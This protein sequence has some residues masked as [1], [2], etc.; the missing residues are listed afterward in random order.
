VDH[1]LP[2]RPQVETA[3]LH[4]RHELDDDAR[5][6]AGEQRS[7]VADSTS[8][9]KRAFAYFYC[10]RTEAERR[11]PENILR[12]FL[13]QLALSNGK[14]LATLH[15]KYMEKKRQGFLSNSLSLTECQELLIKMISQYS[16]TILILDALDECE[17]DSR[18]NFMAVFSRLVEQNLPVRIIISSRPD[19]DISAEFGDGTNF[20]LSATDNS[21][22]IMTFVHGKIEDYRNSKKSK[23]RINSVISDELEQQ[24]IDVFQEKSDGMSV[25]LSTSAARQLTTSRFQWA[26]LHITHLLSLDRPSDI[27]KALPNLPKGLEKTYSE[28]FDRITSPDNSLRDIA[29]RTFHWLLARDGN[30]DVEQLLVIVC[31]DLE[32]DEIRPVDIDPETILKACQNLVVQEGEYNPHDSAPSFPPPLTNW[33]SGLQ[34]QPPSPRAGPPPPPPPPLLRASSPPPPGHNWFGGPPS[35]PR[36]PSSAVSLPP[37]PPSQ[38]NP[39]WDHPHRN[40]HGHHFG[41]GRPG[42][43]LG[44]QQATGIPRSRRPP[45]PFNARPKFR[46]AHLSVQEY[47]ETIQWTQYVAHNF[48]AKICL[49]VLLQ[50]KEHFALSKT[51]YHASRL[52]PILLV[53]LRDLADSMWIYHIQRCCNLEVESQ[54]CRLVALATRFLGF[55]DETSASFERWLSR[56]SWSYR[57]IRPA[58]WSMDSNEKSAGVMIRPPIFGIYDESPTEIVFDFG[59]QSFMV[60]SFFGI[61]RIF[62][63]SKEENIP[64]PPLLSDFSWNTNKMTCLFSHFSTIRMLRAIFEPWIKKDTRQANQFLW[65]VVN[66]IK[67]HPLAPIYTAYFSEYS[68]LCLNLAK[69]VHFL[70]IPDRVEMCGT[71][72]SFLLYPLFPGTRLPTESDEQSKQSFSKIMSLGANIN[73]SLRAA[74]R[75]RCWEDILWLIEE[76]AVPDP[77]ALAILLKDTYIPSPKE[78]SPPIDLC[79]ILIQRGVDVNAEVCDKT[80]WR[81]AP[82]VVASISGKV[83]LVQLLVKTG[84]DVNAMPSKLD[85]TLLE[86]SKVSNSNL[87]PHPEFDDSKPCN[88]EEV[89]YCYSTALIEASARGH[90]EICRLL[91]KHGADAHAR[92]EPKVGR[93][94]TALVAA[95]AYNRPEICKIL[96]DHGADVTTQTWR[97]F[98]LWRRCKATP[99]LTNALITA[100]S[101]GG[102]ECCRLLLAHGADAN[103]IQINESEF[104]GI[105]STALVAAVCNGHTEVCRLLLERGSDANLSVPSAKYPT[106]LIAA[107]SRDLVWISELLVNRGADTD[108]FFP[109]SERPNALICAC[110]WRNLRTAELL[111]MRGAQVNVGP[112]S[113]EYGKALLAACAGFDGERD[114]LVKLITDGAA[115]PTLDV[116]LLDGSVATTTERMKAAGYLYSAVESRHKDAITRLREKLSHNLGLLE[117][118]KIVALFNANKLVALVEL[119]YDPLLITNKSRHHLRKAFKR[120]APKLL[121]NRPRLKD[122]LDK[123]PSFSADMALAY[124]EDRTD[125]NIPAPPGAKRRLRELQKSRRDTDSGEE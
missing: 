23:R 117:D 82:I 67:N 3:G 93:F 17:E 52:C 95:C 65:D 102:L 83:D 106:A 18:Y 105:R 8:T 38:S 120:I 76:E 115:L 111:V 79:R 73:H 71:I 14:N 13:K 86:H 70:G 110:D 57:S 44:W 119:I 63:P 89:G 107:A 109:E 99:Y 108:L 80:G 48:A 55:P 28:I 100:A 72:A 66:S 64:V 40:R 49:L 51:S 1:F 75:R 35:Y 85:G 112:S 31:Q 53:I 124:M 81:Y 113:G 19:D 91:L 25:I 104:I 116:S 92:V 123:V 56:L 12:S 41:H 26:A 7:P 61:D 94:G 42:E 5:S 21:H 47:C 59:R 125:P 9:S 16:K 50:P 29:I 96:L 24:I 33:P 90:V 32:N 88:S 68:L 22:D 118:D 37:S 74:L 2:Q 121:R 45:M 54:D 43:S 98:K 60:V 39:D 97:I 15:T 36:R 34:G 20:K 103:A 87:E 69:L 11:K 46:F 84:A 30:A 114:K 58:F 122:L 78:E 10:R 77:D 6:G 27:E 101:N 4:L 62:F